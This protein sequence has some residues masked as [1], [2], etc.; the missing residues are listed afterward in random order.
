MYEARRVCGAGGDGGVSAHIFVGDALFVPYLAGE[1]ELGGELLRLGREHLG[2]DYAARLVRKVARPAL[3]LAEDA[4]LFERLFAAVEY[5]DGLYRSEPVLLV[6]SEVL[7]EAVRGE[8]AALS[9]GARTVRVARL[10]HRQRKLRASARGGGAGRREG[11]DAHALRSKLVLGAE[12]RY[13]GPAHRLV[14]DRHDE[15]LAR[16]AAEIFVDD[17]AAAEVAHLA[18]QRVERDRLRL[19]LRREYGYHGQRF[20]VEILVLDFDVHLYFLPK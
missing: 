5:R 7:V 12:P 4:S 3:R 13:D 15:Q 1:A 14:R 6:A 16:L 17:D 8:R 20:G 2:V 9:R 10:R 18:A 11:R 19:A